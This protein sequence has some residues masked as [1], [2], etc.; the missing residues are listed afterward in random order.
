MTA[1]D[2]IYAVITGHDRPVPLQVTKVTAKR[3]YYRVPNPRWDPI[4]ASAPPGTQSSWANEPEYLNAYVSREALES[5]GPK[6]LYRDSIYRDSRW[7]DRLFLTQQAAGTYCRWE[8]ARW[9]ASPA[10]LVTGAD[11]KKLRAEMA[12]A[13]PDRGGSRESF[14]VARERYLQAKSLLEV[15][16]S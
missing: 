10:E 3:I 5:A 9:S 6:G 2:F 8:A 13:H 1:P 12:D 7:D 15:S 16:Q 11:V 4:F 14:T